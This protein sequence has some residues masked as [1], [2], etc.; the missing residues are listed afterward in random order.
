[1]RRTK[2]CVPLLEVNPRGIERDMYVKEILAYPAAIDVN[3][4]VAIPGLCKTDFNTVV[5]LVVRNSISERAPEHLRFLY[6]SHTTAIEK[7]RRNDS[8]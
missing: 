7:P 5:F 6:F 3:R 8:P 4:L 2:S 1:M